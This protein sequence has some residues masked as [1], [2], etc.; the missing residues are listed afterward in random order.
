MKRQYWTTETENYVKQYV[1]STDKA[2]KDTIFSKHIFYPLK[3]L[4]AGVQKRYEYKDTGHSK[5]ESLCLDVVSKIYESK[6]D[7]YNPD[8]K[9]KAFSFLTAV[10]TNLILDMTRKNK[11]IREHEE[12]V[13][14]YG[15]L[16]ET[17]IQSYGWL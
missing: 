13:D 14:S 7:K 15:N 9:S 17:L 8:S 11:K 6:L 1:R 10:T 5:I 12:S 3:T 4:V 2:E 16:D